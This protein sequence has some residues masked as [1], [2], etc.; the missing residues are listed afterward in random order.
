MKN[1]KLSF[2][3]IAIIL[4]AGLIS[5]SDGNDDSVH[6]GKASVKATDAAV[7]AQNVNAVY[8]SVDEIQATANGQTK[9]VVAFSSP[10][11]FDIMAYQNG[12]TYF[13]GEGDLDAGSYSDLRFITSSAADSYVELKD[14][15]TKQLEIENGSTTGYRIQG[16]F[17]IAASTTTDLVADIDLR[18]ALVTTANGT[19]KLRSTARVVMEN[20]TGKIKGTVSG[21]GDASERIVVYAY[22]KGSFSASEENEP[23]EGRT[24]YEGSINSAIVAENGS[25]TLA[26]MEEGEYEIIVA[27]YSNKDNDEDLEFEGRLSSSLTINGILF[28]T[29]NVTSRSTVSANITIN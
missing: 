8:L 29:I 26:F 1:L 10:Q 9:T 21:S 12:A 4:T 7:D 18:K 5:C 3:I 23:T 24:R 14:G 22:E 2:K 11:K 27:S 19:F 16:A 20:Q 13:M 28:N 17:D 6:K 25:Y 15:T